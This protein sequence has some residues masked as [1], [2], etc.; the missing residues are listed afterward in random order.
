MLPRLQEQSELENFEV[1]LEND[2]GKVL[3][4]VSVNH[5]KPSAKHQS[6]ACVRD[7]FALQEASET[8]AYKHFVEW[9]F[10]QTVSGES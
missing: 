1:F 2:E 9:F 6:V 8:L 3:G 7:I 5:N 10:G 4:K